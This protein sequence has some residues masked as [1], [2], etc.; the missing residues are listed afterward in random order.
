MTAGRDDGEKSFEP[1]QKR[2][3][4]ARA[5]GDLPQSADLTTAA[6]YGGFI[7]ACL[8]FG[9]PALVRAGDS[10]SALL[11]APDSLALAA[12]GT[13]RLA[14]LSG[15]A[16]AVAGALAPFVLLPAAA[17]LLAI[18]GQQA[19]VVATDRIRPKAERISP[20][21]TISKKFGVAGLVEFTK[22]LAKLLLFSVVL[23]VFLAR[24]LPEILSMVAV[25]P[26][27]ATAALLGMTLEFLAL[28]AAIALAIG[29]LDLLWQRASH[30]RRH[31]MTRKELRDEIK[32]SEGDPMLKQQRR[33]RGVE[34]ALNRQLAE[35]PK[36]EVVIVN[37]THYAVALAWDRE[38]GR[39]PV[40]V[41]K[42]VDEIAARIRAIAIEHG[43]PIH[44]DPATARALHAEVAVGEEIARRHYRAV[45]AAIRFA[46]RMRR[47]AK[48]V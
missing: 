32:E 10:L 8:A 28:V 15:F 34:I 47:K 9:G 21:A 11:A 46:E 25:A 35:V 30:R 42:G 36:A 48:G 26:G 4:D 29:L 17:A 27:P 44:S 6:A 19:L 22:S 45:A 24:R 14:P 3:E 2:L 40:C 20:L 43:V 13:A 16:A 12:F 23:G 7:L 18:I 38:S 1:S 41:A 39:A 31:M 37:P 33:S 5:K